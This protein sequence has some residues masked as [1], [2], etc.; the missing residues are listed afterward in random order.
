[1]ATLLQ[2]RAI[3][4]I[5][6]SRSIGEAMVKAGYSPISATHPQQ[7]TQSKAWPALMEKYL[8]DD[9]LAKTHKQALKATKLILSPTEPDREVPDHAIR[10]K[11]VELGYKLKHRIGPDVV[12]QFNTGGNMSLEFINDTEPDQG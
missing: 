1:M 4:L 2:K 9:K 5:E 12:A 3:K 10:L 8:P 6:S 11:A 7:L